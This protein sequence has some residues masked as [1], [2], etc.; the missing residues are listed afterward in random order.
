MKKVLC[1]VLAA[2]M[3]L[4]LV[5]CGNN[6]AAEDETVNDVETVLPEG[7]ENV[8]EDEPEQLPEEE[9]EGEQPEEEKPAQQPEAKPEE[10]PEILQPE[11]E[12]P[13]EEETPAADAVAPLDVLTGAWNAMG[14]DEKFP[15]AG[16]D[17]NN[18]V[19]DAPGAFNIADAEALDS[20]L[21]LNAD[22]AAK[23]DAAASLMHMMNANTFTCGAF[24]VIAGEDVSAF[25]SAL[26]DNI[27]A[28]QWMCGFPEK[29]VIVTIDNCVVSMFGNGQII[30]SF[31]AKITANYA[32]A[33][34]VVDE[35]IQ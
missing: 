34:I 29:L 20:M 18:S 24:N 33:S 25:V 32:S 31:T 16:G 12:K 30:D 23:I 4:S 2:V 28:R 26:K 10:K 8:T 21:G 13:A 5:S 15:I 11:E 6:N 9:T 22:G 14:D 19:M 1:L 3:I 7:E 17:Y 35:A 27:Q